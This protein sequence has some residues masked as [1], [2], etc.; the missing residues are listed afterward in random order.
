[1]VYIKESYSK[2]C[3]EGNRLRDKITALKKE[4]RNKIGK[5]GLIQSGRERAE[6]KTDRVLFQL[7]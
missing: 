2:K 4:L 6:P 1:M 3:A 5:E 7:T